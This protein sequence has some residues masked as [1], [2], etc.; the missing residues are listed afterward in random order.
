MGWTG[1][2]SFLL[3]YKFGDKTVIIRSQIHRWS[4][5]IPFLLSS[6]LF[7][8]N[9]EKLNT[10][11][12]KTTKKTRLV[13]IWSNERAMLMLSIKNK[14]AVQFMKGKNMFLVGALEQEMKFFQ[15]LFL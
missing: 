6:Y 12:V 11:A 8:E 15:I 10:V 9:F 7:G 2:S 13:H 14:N 1:G 5:P 4:I 3:Q